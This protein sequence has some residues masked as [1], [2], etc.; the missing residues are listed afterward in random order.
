MKPVISEE[1]WELLS[2]FL[3]EVRCARAT[4][5]D[6]CNCREIG[7]FDGLNTVLLSPEARKNLKGDSRFIFLCPKHLKTAMA[8]LNIAD[9]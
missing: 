4:R 2:L 5:C 3:H 7:D 6:W 1:C 8:N 9:E